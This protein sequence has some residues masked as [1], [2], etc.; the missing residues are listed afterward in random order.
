MGEGKCELVRSPR[1][2][3]ACRGVSR[4]LRAGVV[5]GGVIRFRAVSSA[6]SCTGGMTSRRPRKAIV[7]DRRRAGKGK[8]VNER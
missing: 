7:V 2:L 1:S 4:G 5:K 8:E 3:L 6:G